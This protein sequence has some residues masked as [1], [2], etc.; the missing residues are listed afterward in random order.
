VDTQAPKAKPSNSKI[1]P[2]TLKE[3]LPSK[4]NS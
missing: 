1:P 4:L 2:S 3:N